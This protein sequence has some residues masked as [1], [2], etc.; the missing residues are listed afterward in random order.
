MVGPRPELRL[1]DVIALVVGIVVGAGIFRTPSLVAANVES[2]THFLVLWL[3]GGGISLIGALCYAELA[4]T[5]PHV[6]G[7]YHFLARAFGKGV[8]FLFA[9]ARMT[10]IQTGSIALL[11]FVFGDYASQLFWLGE[12]SSALYAALLVSALTGLNLLGLRFGKWTQNL[13]TTLEILGVLCVIGAGLLLVTP[14][15]S[16]GRSPGTVSP[17]SWGLAMIFVLLTYGGWNEAAYVSAEIKGTR[18][19]ML[20]ALLGGV[21]VISAVY[22]L[23]N[24]AYVRGLGLAEMAAVDAVAAELLRRAVGE[25]G[26]QVISVI[27]LLAAL[28]SA[29]ASIITGARSNY[30]LGRDFALFAALGRWH[31]RA[32]TPTTALLVQGAITLA[33]VLLGLFTRTGFETMVEYTAPVFWFFFLLTGVALIV[34]RWREPEIDRPFRVPLFPLLP[35]LFCATAAYL[36]YSSLAYTGMGA[37]VGV[38]VLAIGLLFLWPA[39]LRCPA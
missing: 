37:F 39:R 36:L 35:L 19:T 29:N 20:W 14:E 25:G 21:G 23:A 6:G 31:G 10:V 22:L 38:A 34:L 12:S 1:C 24:W 8:A 16:P 13:L 27:V 33:L 30:A 2:E 26:A 28:T 3:L 17:G 32:N 9:W 5:Y 15:V 11:A 7:D 4:T 18:R